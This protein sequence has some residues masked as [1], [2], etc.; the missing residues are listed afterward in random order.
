MSNGDPSPTEHTIAQG[1]T[2]GVA[3]AS[4]GYGS[5]QNNKVQ[6]NYGIGVEIKDGS[7]PVFQGN[8]ITDGKQEGILVADKAAGE[9]YDNIVSNNMRAGLHISNQGAPIARGNKFVD[10]LASGVSVTNGG[11]G[12]LESNQISNNRRNGVTVEGYTT[13]KRGQRCDIAPRAHSEFNLRLWRLW[14]DGG[15][16]RQGI[17]AP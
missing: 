17:C 1:T 12:C 16:L 15:R 6:A 5:F 7:A 11:L 13:S 9:V 4:G 10:G 8:S 2:A 3:V 14:G